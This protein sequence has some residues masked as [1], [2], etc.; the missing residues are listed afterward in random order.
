MPLP[1][2]RPLVRR[3]CGLLAALGIGLGAAVSAGAQDGGVLQ[4]DEPQGLVDLWPAVTVLAD[5]DASADWRAVLRRLDE[6]AAPTGTARNLGLVRHPVWMAVQVRANGG[7]GR[8]V[9]NLDYPPFNHIELFTIAHGQLRQ[10]VVLGST[11]A[12]A[13]RPMHARSHAVELNLAPGEK[14]LLLLRLRSDSA[15]LLPI[16]LSTPAAFVAHES[17]RLVYLGLMFGVAVALLVYSL[18]HAMALRNRLFAL[19][20]G[21]L[22]GNTLFFVDVS[23]LAQV[24][25]SSERRGLMAMM[26][27]LSVYLAMSAGASFVTRSLNTQLHSPR[28]HRGLQVLAVVAGVLLLA[29]LVGALN[30]RL[31]QVMATLI[32]PI[33][34]VLAIPAAWRRARQGERI[35]LY[36]LLGWS[37][38]VFGALSM[39]SLLHGLLPATVWTMNMY[40]MASMLEMAAWFR[41]LGLGVEALQREAE[42]N[43]AAVRDLSTIAT[44]DA[45]TGLPNRRGLDAELPRALQRATGERLLA[46]YLIDLDG[47]KAVNDRLGHAAGDMLLR[48]VAQR[49][50]DA[51]RGGDMVARLGGD[52]FVVLT[53]GLASEADAQTVGSKLLDAFAHPVTVDG[54]PCRIGLT[55]GFA[56][57]PADS[58]EPAELM[59]RADSAMYAGKRDGRHQLRRHTEPLQRA[60]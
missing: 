56:L 47:F 36:M 30:Y 46:L 26:S 38:Y 20:G 42:H 1:T 35:G 57:A 45:L 58:C 9:F 34:P 18:A 16:S 19:Y 41:V 7:S 50:K 54:S 52:E 53:E 33:V 12:F 21:L 39:V 60:A 40:Q 59:R 11:L 2:L 49:L 24:L 23:G 14:H 37:C 48:E 5:V 31:A 8:W 28:L 51:V 44:T 29:G 22:L 32:G 27:P 25:L 13:D 55:I 17:R 6:F 10:H 4:L 43:A 3:G 15:M